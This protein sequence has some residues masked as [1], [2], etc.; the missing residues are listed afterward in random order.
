MRAKCSRPWTGF[1][2]Y[3]NVSWPPLNDEPADSSRASASAAEYLERWAPV[4]KNHFGIMADRDLWSTAAAPP[5]RRLRSGSAGSSQT[6][7]AA[8]DALA[9]ERRLRENAEQEAADTRALLNCREAEV[10]GLS[11]ELASLRS[12]ATW[13]WTQGFLKSQAVKVLFGGLIR[14]VARRQL[15]A[16]NPSAPAPGASPAVFTDGGSR[17]R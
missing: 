3:T 12:S 8:K 6:S 10:T 15:S 16:D 13:R 17:R 1:W 9:V 14:S 4:Y 11:R 2:S 5:N 7:S